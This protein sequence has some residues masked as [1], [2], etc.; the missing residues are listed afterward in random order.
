VFDKNHTTFNDP[1]VIN[2]TVA[3]TVN[4]WSQQLNKYF[5]EVQNYNLT[6]CNNETFFKGV[7]DQ[8]NEAA[9][10]NNLK[11]ILPR[12]KL[13]QYICPENIN[14]VGLVGGQQ[15]DNNYNFTSMYI[16]KC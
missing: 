13:D 11:N 1:S 6:P 16:S 7:N 5:N 3:T 4:T 15:Y 14:T 2:F 9:N 8:N 10:L 12:I